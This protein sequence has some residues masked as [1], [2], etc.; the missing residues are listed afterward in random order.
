M[1]LTQGPLVRVIL[2]LQGE[3]EHVVFLTMHHI[4]SDGWS[5]GV[6]VRELV[7]LYDAFSNGKPFLLPELSIQYADFAVWQ[8]QWLQGEVLESQ[9]AYWKKQLEGAPPVLQLPTDRPRPPVQSF[10]GSQYPLAFS[11]T[12][13]ET[14]NNLSRQENTTLFM[15]LLAA[16]KT[17]LWR[18]TGQDD[19]IVGFPIANRNRAQVENLIGFFVNTLVMRTQLGGNLT[20]RELIGRVR[21]V[22]LDAYAHQDLPFHQ[23][24]EVLQPKRNL[25]YQPL[26]QVQL[27]LQNAPIEA[28]EVPG[29]IISPLDADSGTAKFDLVMSLTETE[30]GLEGWLDYSTDLFELDTINRMARHFQTLLEN[31]IADPDQGL[32]NLPLLTEA[33][34]RQLLVEWNDTQAEYPQDKCIH[35]LFAAQVEQSHDAIA[36][37]FEDEHLTY[38]ELNQRANQLAS[39]LQAMGIRPEL[40][41]GICMERSLEMI[42]GLL[43]ILKAGGAYVP[44]D[45][46]Y[47][48][49]RLALTLEDAQVSVLLTQERL[50]EALPAL[51]VHVICLDTDWEMIAQEGQE[52]LTTGV[53]VDNTAYVIYTS[54]STG[55]PKGVIL[56]HRGLCNLVEA[57]VKAFGVQASSRILQF[58]NFSFDASVSEIFTSLVSGATLCLGNRNTLFLVNEL[59]QLL[60]RQQI[61]VVTLPPS[62]LN[63][64]SEKNLTAL[65]TLIVAGERAVAEQLH[66]WCGDRRVFNAYGPTETTVC[67]SLLEYTVNPSQQLSI[68]RPIGNIQI[69]ILDS[70][71]NPLPVGM[72]GELHIGGVGL[73]RGYLNRAELTAEKFIP[74]PFST[75]AGDRLYKTGDLV[76]Y[77]P[78]GSI[79]FLGRM[80]YQVKLRGLRIELKEIEVV[81]R[82][83]TAVQDTVVTVWEDDVANDQR[84][85]AYL[86]ANQEQAPTS[87]DLRSF[88]KQKLPEYM[89]PSFF[90]PLQA[91]PLT[92]NGKIDR[93]A[94]PDPMQTRSELE[95][96]WVAPYTPTEK[97]L[98]SIWVE[99]LG[100]KQVSIHDNFF[101]LGGHSLLVVRLMTQ[102]QQ[103]FKKDLP[104]AVLFQATTIKHLARILDQP[105]DSLPWSPLVVIQSGGSKRPLF[106]VH[107]VG[108]TVLHFVDLARH[109]GP[110]QPFYGLQALGIDEGQKPHTQ[111]EEMAAY[112]IKA[113]QAVQDQGPYLLAGWSF[114][115]LVAFEMA[116]QLQAQGQKV[117]FLGLLDTGFPSLNWEKFQEDDAALL[118]DL[119][120]G[121]LP[122]SLDDLQQLKPDE[123]LIY[124]IELAKQVNLIPPNPGIDRLRPILQVCKNNYRAS[125]SYV[126]QPYQGRVT[127]FQACEGVTEVSQDLAQR[128]RQLASEEIELCHVPGNHYTMFKTP[129]VQVLAELLRSC[130]EGV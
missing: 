3:Q 38:W 19:L 123:Q 111:L 28:L 117:S 25:S 47:P 110:D 37:V 66:R 2:L 105:T 30:Q 129:H 34:Q 44:L 27:V 104:L 116:Q 92:S 79:Q 31:I 86:V 20:F 57:Q 115:G 53:T 49:K 50:T 124:L 103:Q 26:F 64:L 101:E 13:T 76:C 69:Y 127:F 114:G 39:H 85:V 46:E 128:W 4:V 7:A 125:H 108:G 55:K 112:Y 43:G 96:G 12:L 32:S 10:R 77:L 91:L 106:C 16:F 98:A 73:A 88:L 54:G 71:L 83:H 87:S 22:A 5:M 63:L 40:R 9:L 33:E 81:L 60:Q 74:N 93:R 95:L 126:A 102:I 56:E 130:L 36:V 78:D 14:L 48:L 107:A 58:A 1:D 15:T 6:F 41:V 59:H 65:Q 68:G 18:Y 24:L 29:L 8:R 119:F 35:H 75:Q 99:V 61:T 45:P 80:D 42:V 90:V 122:L 121:N 23:L 21:K 97:I 84:L 100:L 89:V 82:Q 70:H 11:K 113:V 109:L 62:I 120:G 17:L 67:V 72:P 94:L 118:I 51:W 52:N